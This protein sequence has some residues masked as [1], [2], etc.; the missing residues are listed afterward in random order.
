[1]KICAEHEKW[2]VQ[3]GAKGAEGGQIEEL[4]SST[5]RHESERLRN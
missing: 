3:I 2:Y 4:S 5:K 1:M